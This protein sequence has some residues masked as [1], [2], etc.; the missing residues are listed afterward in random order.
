ML[1]RR[2]KKVKVD[3]KLIMGKGASIVATSSAGV[4]TALDMTEL[5]ALNDIAAADLAGTRC[6]KGDHLLRAQHRVV[7]FDH[8][9]R[10]GQQHL[11]VARHAAEARIEKHRHRARAQVGE[12]VV[13]LVQAEAGLRGIV[14]VAVRGG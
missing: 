3:G 7:H 5:A 10:F 6:G 12:L 11:V 2:F 8:H 14:G 1:D 13:K 9:A 4:E